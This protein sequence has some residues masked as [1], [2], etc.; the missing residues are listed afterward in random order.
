VTPGVIRIAKY[1]SGA[2]R[3]GWR[4]WIIVALAAPIATT[5]HRTLHLTSVR[6][7]C[8]EPSNRVDIPELG[9]F[10]TRHGA[11]YIA[12]FLLIVGGYLFFD[13]NRRA[14]QHDIAATEL[15]ASSP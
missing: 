4:R 13:V 11:G 14:R 5:V 15:R 8:V 2:S 1:L 10:A 12:T 7:L 6:L 9:K 3:R